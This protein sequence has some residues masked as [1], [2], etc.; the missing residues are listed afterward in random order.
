M[1]RVRLT[2]AADEVGVRPLALA[3]SYGEVSICGFL[4]GRGADARAA[5]AAG[6]TARLGRARAQPARK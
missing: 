6:A 3:A 1:L 4:L 5:D 2:Q